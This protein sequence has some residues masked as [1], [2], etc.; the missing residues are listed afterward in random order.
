[1]MPLP[2]INRDEILEILGTPFMMGWTEWESEDVPDEYIVDYYDGKEV[3]YK[4]IYFHHH[5]P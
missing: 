1:M 4:H 2:Y 5:P 3:P